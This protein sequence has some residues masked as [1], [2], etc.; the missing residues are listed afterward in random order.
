MQ[1]LP[2]QLSP[3]LHGQQP[4]PKRMVLLRNLALLLNLSITIMA[5]LTYDVGHSRKLML[6][7]GAIYWPIALP[8][9]VRHWKSPRLPVLAFLVFG[10]III[11][12]TLALIFPPPPRS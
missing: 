5:V 6:I 1:M 3:V 8:L 10:Q 12:V 11:T 4:T 2:R 9:Y 7:A